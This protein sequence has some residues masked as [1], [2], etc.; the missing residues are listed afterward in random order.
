MKVLIIEDDYATIETI[1]L[2]LQVG[3]QEAKVESTK[4]GREGIE[5]AKRENPDVVILDLGL[6]DIDGFEVIKAIRLFSDVP[7]I[8][9]TVRG[10][11]A[12]IIKGL[13]WG[14]DE[15]IIKPFRRLE[16]LARIKNV[17]KKQHC[18]GDKSYLR[19]GPF[20]LDVA[21]R[22]LKNGEKLI[23]LTSIE[24]HILYYLA[25]NKG[26]VLTYN[27]IANEVWGHNYPG[28]NEALRVHIRHLRKKIEFDATKPQLILT[29]P[30]IGYMLA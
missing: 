13:E 4:M 17:L 19:F 23:G 10:E 2:S 30:G 16:L 14:A 21:A 6:P 29:K 8:V 28:T 25:L 18:A 26:N 15:Y 11:E 20:E 9:L 5:L 3:W 22:K 12:E 24:S 1:S 7:V 27:S